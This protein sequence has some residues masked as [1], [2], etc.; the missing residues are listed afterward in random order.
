MLYIKAEDLR[1]IKA[2]H[3]LY[4]AK[5]ACVI[6]A[7]RGQE[8]CTFSY[9]DLDIEDIEDL[10]KDGLSIKEFPNRVFGNFVVSWN[11]Q[12]GS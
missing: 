2:R 12:D 10:K 5:R 9:G 1:N 11:K 7:E 4:R 6:A 8:S 3:K